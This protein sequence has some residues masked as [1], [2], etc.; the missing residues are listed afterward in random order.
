MLSKH[1]AIPRKQI[2]KFCRRWQVIEFSLFGSALREDFAQDSDVDV[3][4]RFAP[5]AKISLFDM[6]QMQIELEQLFQRSVDLLE[7]DAL[8]NPYRKR[9]IMNTAQVIYSR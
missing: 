3:L 6:A 5:E 7:K 1:F 8:R 9:E 2:I 4:V